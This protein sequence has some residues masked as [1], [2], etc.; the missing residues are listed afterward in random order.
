M[1]VFSVPPRVWVD[2]QLVGAPL[3][4]DLQV[5]CFIEASPRSITYWLKTGQTTPLMT[6]SGKVVE[7][8]RV[9]YKTVYRLRISRFSSRDAGT[10]KCVS[11]NS[12]GR[13][14]VTIRIYG[15]EIF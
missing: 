1:F 7:E 11:E 15:E 14:E 13:D 8:E 12:L 3:D 6:G 2:S 10:Y 4:H 9:G 5:E